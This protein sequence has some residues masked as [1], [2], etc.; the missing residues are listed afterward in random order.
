[1]ALSEIQPARQERFIPKTF[2]PLLST[3]LNVGMALGGYITTVPF[4]NTDYPG[5]AIAL[6]FKD[7]FKPGFVGVT[8]LGALTFGSGLR[9]FWFHYHGIA[10]KQARSSTVSRWSLAGLIFTLLHF[11]FGNQVLSIMDQILSEPE[12]AQLQMAKWMSMHV[13]RTLIADV[14]AWMCFIVALL[15]EI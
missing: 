6:W 13:T 12:L 9:A 4:H 14:P 8:T 11:G 7:F 2:L 5:P 15:Y 3:S 10:Q 1:M